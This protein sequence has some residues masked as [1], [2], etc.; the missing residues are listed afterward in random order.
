MHLKCFGI[1]FSFMS[2]VVGMYVWWPEKC[3]GFL[4]ILCYV[5]CRA[6]GDCL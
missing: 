1:V 4:K 3:N 6:G 5:W 2:I